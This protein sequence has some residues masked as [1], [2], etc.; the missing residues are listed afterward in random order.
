MYITFKFSNFCQ[1]KHRVLYFLFLSGPI[2][3]G[4]SSRPYDDDADE[5]S[6]NIVN[7]D[8]LSDYCGDDDDDRE[9]KRKCPFILSEAE[10]SGCG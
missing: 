8:D 1:L 3:P 5:H 6:S 9:P 7:F 4:F 2:D 10:E